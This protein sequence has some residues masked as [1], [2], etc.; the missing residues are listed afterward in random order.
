MTEAV[1]A[2]RENVISVGTNL[3]PCDAPDTTGDESHAIT[4][5]A[6]GRI[7]LNDWIRLLQG[8][9]ILFGGSFAVQCYLATGYFLPHDSRTTCILLLFSIAAFGFLGQDLDES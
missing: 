5:L 2:P 6:P 9:A 1:D 8:V 3:D 7:P 4:V